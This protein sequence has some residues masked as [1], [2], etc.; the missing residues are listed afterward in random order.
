M[1]PIILNF[2][3]KYFS[4]QTSKPSVLLSANFARLSL[5]RT[6]VGPQNLSGLFEE[7]KNI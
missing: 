5:N 2:V 4:R 3:T 6:L 1:A 7:E